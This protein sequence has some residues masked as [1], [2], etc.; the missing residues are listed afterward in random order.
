M[1]SW[2]RSILPGPVAEKSSRL[3][4]AG[5]L[6]CLIAATFR[7]RVSRTTPGEVEGSAGPVA[8]VGPATPA[9][10]CGPCGPMSPAAPFAPAAPVAPTALPEP[11][12]THCEALDA[13][14]FP[15]LPGISEI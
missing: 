4:P 12:S 2:I 11:T 1:A 3:A 5:R 10:P 15:T 9:G 8:P 14:V 6:Y 7:V 13:G